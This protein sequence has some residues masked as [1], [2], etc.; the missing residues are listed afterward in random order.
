MSF[1]PEYI[2]NR[3]FLCPLCKKYVEHLVRHHYSYFPE[4]T[5]WICK[6]CDNRTKLEREH[7]ELCPPKDDAIK[8]YHKGNKGKTDEDKAREERENQRWREIFRQ[9]EM[10]ILK[11]FDDGNPVAKIS[12]DLHL[13]K[14][15]VIRDLARNNRIT[16]KENNDIILEKRIGFLGN[17]DF[18]LKQGKYSRI[19]DE[20][21]VFLHEIIESLFMIIE[22]EKKHLK[23]K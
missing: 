9:E 15:Q 19:V 7:P 14:N 8:F 22:F 20:D 10:Q 17:I 6:G 18:N 2:D 3:L 21:D 16:I 13:S 5:M 23:L 11:M 12:N 4:K 1:E